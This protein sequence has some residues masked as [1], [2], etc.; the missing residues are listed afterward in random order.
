[1]AEYSL[2]LAN[3]E[4]LHFAVNYSY[5]E[6]RFASYQGG[7]E[8]TETVRACEVFDEQPCCQAL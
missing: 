6:L 5:S 8:V 1:M 4:S 7:G 2:Y 3:A